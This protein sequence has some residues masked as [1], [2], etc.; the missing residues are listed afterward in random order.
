MSPRDLTAEKR[1]RN[2]L[3]EKQF[4][5]LGGLEL[6]SSEVFYDKQIIGIENK[7]SDTQIEKSKHQKFDFHPDEEWEPETA[8]IP[9]VPPELMWRA[10]DKSA[11]ILLNRNEA[12]KRI[13]AGIKLKRQER[14][15]LFKNLS[16]VQT[17]ESLFKYIGKLFDREMSMPSISN[18]TSE[19]ELESL[20]IDD[21][22]L[23]TIQSENET[24][25]SEVNYRQ[26]KNIEAADV[27]PQIRKKPSMPR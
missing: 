18:K 27:R 17:N 22:S 4:V 1:N 8:E 25:E 11:E 23:A 12:L 7:Y 3:S 21:D 20:D 6:S 16:K 13:D 2:V 14:H 15:D 19:I 24:D 10:V 9:F 26:N 5:K